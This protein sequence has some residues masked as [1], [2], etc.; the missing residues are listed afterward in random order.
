MNLEKTC[1]RSEYQVD[2]WIT[3]SV[4]MGIFQSNTRKTDQQLIQQLGATA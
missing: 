3:Q 2:F 1:H 4:M